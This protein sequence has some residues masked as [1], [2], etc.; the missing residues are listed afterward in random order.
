MTSIFTDG[1][2]G[3]AMAKRQTLHLNKESTFINFIYAG[4]LGVCYLK[5]FPAI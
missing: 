2:V 4:V 1:S 3:L 5:G